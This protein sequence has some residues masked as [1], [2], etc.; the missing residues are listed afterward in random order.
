M[1]VFLLITHATPSLNVWI[2]TAEEIPL[3]HFMNYNKILAKVEGLGLAQKPKRLQ[4][5]LRLE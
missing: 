5:K 1:C 3:K 2:H 4:I